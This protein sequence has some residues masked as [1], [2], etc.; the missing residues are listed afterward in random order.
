MYVYWSLFFNEICLTSFLEV[1]ERDKFAKI[2]K[3]ALTNPTFFVF[4]I[5]IPLNSTYCE[6]FERIYRRKFKKI[7]N[8]DVKTVKKKPHTCMSGHL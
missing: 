2:G 7:T 3:S 4:K 5:C 8:K 6:N 1:V